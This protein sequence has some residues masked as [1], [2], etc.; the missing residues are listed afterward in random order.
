[1]NRIEYWTGICVYGMAVMVA[2]GDGTAAWT[3]GA[4]TLG[5]GVVTAQ[6]DGAGKVTS[7]AAVL[8]GDTFTLSGT[9]A[10]EF[11]SDATLSV[12]NGTLRVEVPVAAA[13]ALNLSTGAKFFEYIATDDYLPKTEAAAVVVAAG[14]SLDS[15]QLRFA[16][17]KRVMTQHNFGSN[18]DS[19]AMPFFVE[20]SAG[21]LSCQMQLNEGGWTK[22]V[23]LELRQRGD[24]VVAWTPKA[25]YM[26]QNDRPLGSD[27]RTFTYNT[28]GVSSFVLNVDGY[29]IDSLLL[30]HDVEACN[31][32]FTKALDVGGR[33]TIGVGLNV[34]AEGAGALSD[35]DDWMPSLRIDGTFT[36]RN[37]A[38]LRFGGAQEYG[39]FG[40]L[41]LKADDEPTSTAPQTISLPAY[42]GTSWAT[43]LPNTS[44]RS[45]TNVTAIAAGGW[46]GNGSSLGTYHFTNDGAFA[47][48]QH[49][50][51]DGVYIKG[52]V[53]K[54]R[55]YGGDVQAC[56]LKSC[57]FSTS[58]DERG[59]DLLTHATTPMNVF[60]NGTENGYGLQKIKVVLSEPLSAHG[61][62]LAGRCT[63]NAL[64]E[65]TVEGR[66]RSRMVLQLL[67][68]LAC[69]TP[70]KIEEGGVL[71]V[72]PTNQ[73]YGT[74]IARDL[75]VARGGEFWQ[76]VDWSLN[77]ERTTITCSGGTIRFKYDQ[78]QTDANAY[79]YIGNVN[80]TDGGL[81]TGLCP[82][83]GYYANHVIRVT[84]SHPATIDTS[85]AVMG[86]DTAWRTLTFDVADVTGDDGADL[87]LNGRLFYGEAS[88]AIA[89]L[90]KTGAGTVRALGRNTVTNRTLSVKGGTWLLAAGGIMDA[91]NNVDLA[92]GALATETVLTN[93]F[94]TLSV[95]TNKVG[96]LVLGDAAEFDFHSFELSEGAT[97]A[98]R[99]G[100]NARVRIGT[101]QCLSAATR[102]R[103]SLNGGKVFQMKDGYLT[104]RPDG[105]LVLIR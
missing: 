86:H 58:R 78:P 99:A 4:T 77:V 51:F 79:A 41:I 14:V 8:N 43:V 20:R 9:D 47:T 5:D 63:D 49:Q 26:S 13:G 2:R 75:S 105:T 96:S 15:L 73:T 42:P 76:T 98:I 44:L 46:F 57:Y 24:D 92:G 23:F 39:R 67:N 11:A 80:F 27:F 74:Y 1:M 69:R 18:P 16:Y 62:A 25:G 32:V 10:V 64:G 66:P 94:G 48:S 102:A 68:S 65:I 89:H 55:Q 12:S 70:L 88:R 95:N 90:E 61:V 33:L 6:Y 53:Y 17:Y 84:G 37:C 83:W 85:I 21:A 103:I 28:M 31:L 82:R 72:S 87:F 30:T 104:D 7:L 19:I 81:F 100:E 50:L 93:A 36:L 34:L 59:V 56:V 29:G 97:L 60:T 40:K 3:Q 101:T 91:L 38:N 54:F 52:V 22:C 45:I 71:Q 35:T